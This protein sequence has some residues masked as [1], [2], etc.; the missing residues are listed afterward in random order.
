MNLPG[1]TAENAVLAAQQ[2]VGNR[3]VQH[4]L[5]A[6]SQTLALGQ[7]ATVGNQAVQRLL[8]RQP[9]RSAGGPAAIRQST[10]PAPIQRSPLS[11][12][13]ERAWNPRHEKGAVFDLL[14]SRGP[15]P[16]D[17]D[18]TAVLN[19][20]FEAG[21]DDLWLARKIQ[22][23]G[24]EPLWPAA[25]IEERAR[26][27]W[28]SEPGH[29]QAAL[30]TSAQGRPINAYFFPGRTDNRA[31]IISGVHGS[32]LSGI[33]VVERLLEQLRTGPRP[34]YTVIIVPRLFPD[35]A[36]L[37]E[38]QPAEI[39][40]TRNV[41]R[42]TPGASGTTAGTP[43][44]VNRQ[45]PALGRGF[46]PTNPKDAGGRPMELETVALLTLVDRFRPSRIASVH[47]VRAP[48]VAGIFADPRTDASGRALGFADD[49]RLAVDMA[50][51]A[52]GR[53]ANVPANQLAGGT[54]NAIYPRD[55]A[56]VAAGTNQP[57]NTTGGIS[58]GG[59]FSTEVRDPD[60]PAA[61]RAAMTVI[62]V[63]VQ[64][65]RRIQDVPTSQ[66]SAREL[67]IDAHASALREIFLG[68]ARPA[69]P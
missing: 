35:N 21:S 40:S 3:A 45:Y 46:D 37:A 47:A 17:A 64:T 29:I 23:H 34:Y 16:S 57:R 5:R 11:D 32:E 26:R 59:W 52:G 31:L 24:P 69:T 48:D 30:A 38:S 66:R 56:A 25:L 60:R 55:P 63:E 67:E 62:T 1:S 44:V 15:A 43:G 7:Q 39:G 9:G 4:A 49:E 14:R 18:L 27:G 10:S 2:A 19:R 33:E 53:G 22:T 68:P 20:I 12:A 51:H 41:G 36:A 6:D 42:E 58:G 28:P 13:V 54:P 50:R 8:H 61:N 65:S